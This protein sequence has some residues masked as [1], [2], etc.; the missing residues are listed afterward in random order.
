MSLLSLI[1]LSAEMIKPTARG[2]TRGCVLVV[3]V[4]GRD[5]RKGV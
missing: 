1:S 3:L 5:R 2:R 4:V